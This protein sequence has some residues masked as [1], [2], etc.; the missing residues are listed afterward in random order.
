MKRQLLESQKELLLIMLAR[1]NQAQLEIQKTSN[2]TAEELGIPK[3][4]LNQWK[5][6]PNLDYFEKP[7]PP[8]KK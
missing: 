5:I 3:Q 7:E 8:N 6:S 4:E 1:T 2:R